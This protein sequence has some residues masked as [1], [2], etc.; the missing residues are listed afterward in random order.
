MSGQPTGRATVIGGPTTAAEL[1]LLAQRELTT[2][3]ARAKAGVVPAEQLAHAW[4]AFQRAAEHLR[5]A[6]QPDERRG[7]TSRAPDRDQPALAARPLDGIGDPQLLRAADLLG[8]AGDLLSTRERRGL[9]SPDAAMDVAL[10]M[11][12][13]VTGA[14]L[15]ARSLSA[16]AAWVHT[17][18]SAA[19]T[20]RFWAAAVPATLPHSATSSLSDVR[21]WPPTPPAGGDLSGRLEAAINQWRRSALEAARLPAPSS[22]DLRD[23]L[24]TTKVLLSLPQALLKAYGPEAGPAPDLERTA[25]RIRD[26]WRAAGETA[27][28]WEGLTT[29]TAGSAQLLAAT[30]TLFDAVAAVAHDGAAWASSEAIRSRMPAPDGL[31]LAH[32]ALSAVQDVAEGHAPVVDRLTI[33]GAAY[34]R[35]KNLDPS[36]GRLNARLSNDWLPIPAGHAQLLR[37]GYDQVVDATAAA[38][39][40][41][42][43]LGEQRPA[44]PPPGLPD[45]VNSQLPS[46]RLDRERRPDTPALGRWNQ[47]LQSVDSRLAD[48]PHLPALAAALDRVQLSGHDAPLMLAEA[49]VQAL[50]PQHPARA[51]H[52][53]L[54]DACPAALTP[55]TSTPPATRPKVHTDPMPRTP[56]PVVTRPR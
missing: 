45:D 30:T 25:T 46:P 19:A 13:A 4:P 10:S 29:A 41:Y 51:L 37:S 53:R 7:A 5:G 17:A 54:I 32:L 36:L 52:Y 33:T 14:V 49:A 22:R 3:G 31:R 44:P 16:Q 28:Q 38:R 40:T 9:E 48:D 1:L 43:E 20:A 2:L 21:A 42:L 23:T 34:T 12:C 35:A 26:A 24:R 8:A 6:V 50:D 56:P 47:L 39:L 27:T 11:N 55:Y 15:V 18:S